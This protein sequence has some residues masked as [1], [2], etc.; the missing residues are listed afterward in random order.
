MISLV[1]ASWTRL[2]AIP[3]LADFA[4]NG[5]DRINKKCRQFLDKF[6]ASTAAAGGDL[7]KEEMAK[8][9]R[10]G[11][12]GGGGG[13]ANGGSPKRK[14]AQREEYE[15][16]EGGSPK[17]GKGKG[18]KTSPA[19]AKNGSGG[20]KGKGQAK[21]GAKVK[22]EEVGSDASDEK[23]EISEDEAY[24]YAGWSFSFIAMVIVNSGGGSSC[25]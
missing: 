24:R 18:G 17:K 20:G 22:V 21:D 4:G 13:K 5:G 8:L 9:G 14:N 6:V 19:K 1:L 11:S 12:G 2:Y 3:E 10:R 23:A 15:S 16:E 7:V 25:T